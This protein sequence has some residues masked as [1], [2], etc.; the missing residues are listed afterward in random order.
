MDATNNNMNGSEKPELLQLHL[1]LEG[2][3]DAAQRQT[4]DEL[5]RSNAAARR[6]LDALREEQRLI[7]EALEVRAEPSRRL[8][9]Q[10]LFTLHTEERA[11]ASAARNRKL[12][13]QFIS[14]AGLAAALVFCLWLV[15]PR[16]YTGVGE[17][18]TVAT[19]Q[20]ASG[21]KTEFTA[22]T[23]IYEDDTI[24]TALAQ[25]VRLKL[26]NDAT[27]DLDEHSRLTAL[28]VGANPVL[29]LES[30]R[31][32]LNS[33][34]A[35]FA[36]TIELAQGSV[37]VE[38]GS[39]VDIWLPQ[40][41]NAIWPDRLAF[42]PKALATL[43]SVNATRAVVT[44]FKGKAS[45]TSDKTVAGTTLGAGQRAVLTGSTWTVCSV[46][47]A[48]SHAMDMRDGHSWHGERDSA[49]PQARTPVGLLDSFNFSQLGVR[50]KLT[51]KT[52]PAVL[53]ALQVLH[54][55]MALTQPAAKADMLAQGQGDLRRACEELDQLDDRRRYGRVIEGLAHLERGC[56]LA[57]MN[58]E[59]E[60]QTALN[61][62]E[63]AVI[64]FDE[65]L[66]PLS[67]A[68]NSPLPE[69]LW[70]K[71]LNSAG[72][73]TTML[74][75]SAE[76]QAELLASFH[77]ALAEV[78]QARMLPPADARSVA[79]KAAQEFST[80][81]GQ[82]GSHTETLTARYAEGLARGLA[83]ES[84]KS[85]ESFLDVLAVPLSG[86]SDVTRRAGDGIK[87]AAALALVKEHLLSGDMKKAHAAAEDFVILY[88]LD[89]TGPV[90]AEIDR[91]LKAAE[92]PKTET[93][94]EV[95]KPEEVKAGN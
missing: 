43:L 10:V 63:A 2:R 31:L 40:P 26:Y 18:G 48:N 71:Q 94:P 86:C 33:E 52:T 16:D 91:L 47:L 9:D 87:Q 22:N 55:A 1:Y 34:G 82:I 83:G 7:R 64:A 93:A 8:S 32:G 29:R 24:T 42:K 90:N 45:F 60:N 25:F 12:R 49:G 92:T 27:L 4:I 88:P 65:A 78:W 3:L 50:L 67:A 80:L 54:Q 62:F 19:L 59:Q 77:H 44:V 81:R 28:K 30:G 89:A 68:P 76:N 84:E 95:K 74:D 75:L 36:S 53:E 70:P 79:A 21:E 20:R 61:A 5:L 6:T 38:A 73:A 17:S 15:R 41:S 58:N 23:R 51:E 13:R 35:S 69:A 56:T 39:H 66:R 72:P 85:V 11:R 46:D 37:R 57:A 14:V